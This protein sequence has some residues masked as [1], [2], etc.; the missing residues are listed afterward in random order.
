MYC[1]STPLVLFL[2]AQICFIEDNE[3]FKRGRFWPFI[4][5]RL[6]VLL[7]IVTTMMVNAVV[8][9]DGTIYVCS[10]HLGSLHLGVRFDF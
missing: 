4:G 9:G 8:V 6:K 2:Y 7:G 5:Q 10:L 1:E 3:R